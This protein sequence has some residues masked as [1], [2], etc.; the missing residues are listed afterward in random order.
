MAEDFF[1]KL[2]KG[3]PAPAAKGG[4]DFF[5]QFDGPQK[6]K[7]K[8][9]PSGGSV[10]FANIQTTGKL[11]PAAPR[12]PAQ[13]KPG[14]A[15]EN[16]P[17]MEK[18]DGLIGVG[19]NQNPNLVQQLNS[20][21]LRDGSTAIG[22]VG[23]GIGAVF[24]A[25]ADMVNATG[26]RAPGNQKLKGAELGEFIG[27]G[28][29]PFVGM[30]G[31]ASLPGA[32]A[33]TRAVKATVAAN[34]PPSSAALTAA[35][36]AALAGKKLSPVVAKVAEATKNAVAGPEARWVNKQ[37]K[38]NPY[39]AFD[40][41]VVADLKD[42]TT[43]RATVDKNGKLIAP[44]GRAPVD[45]KVINN[46]EATYQGRFK[47]MIDGFDIPP[48]EKLRYKL[49]LD[50]DH[51]GKLDQIEALRGTPQGDAV[52]D[53]I[54]KTQRLRDMSKETPEFG[55]K[56][57]VRGLVET[58]GAIAPAIAG[59]GAFSVPLG[60][61]GLM[62]ARRATRGLAGG[63]ASRVNMATK[64]INQADRYKAL[65]KR[66]GPSGAIESKDALTAGYNA[67]AAGAG[68][69]AVALNG[70]SVTWVSG[71]TTRVYGAIA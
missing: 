34:K 67:A 64:F 63:E 71:N 21:L 27:I 53:A 31:A 7:P 22:A 62:L 9:A 28:S 58:T 47:E 3:Q 42:L 57:G 52:A 2:A 15:A 19:N 36:G 17:S 48:S 10:P 26:I 18:I 23:K 44:K 55:W 45:I 49:A 33:A 51:S 25:G 12:P 59:A 16:F 40:A 13:V 43:K 14:F 20:K 5:D 41:E 56:A 60:A 69:K 4:G 66:V 32:A 68:G 6:A 1:D 11:A 24:D 61:A 37:A 70:F 50:A 29:M 65:G 46:L 38:N 30:P 35:T 8:V 54:I 39:A